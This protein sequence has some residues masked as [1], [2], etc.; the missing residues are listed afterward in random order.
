MKEGGKLIAEQNK[1]M[2]SVLKEVPA[3]TAHVYRGIWARYEAWCVKRG[4]EIQLRFQNVIRFMVEEI[5]GKEDVDTVSEGLK[6]IAR[7]QG[8]DDE[9]RKKMEAYLNEMTKVCKYDGL[10]DRRVLEKISINMWNP[11]KDSL[12]SKHFKTCQ[13][14]LKFLVDFQWKFVTNLSFEERSMVSVRDLRVVDDEKRGVAAIMY[15]AGSE[16]PAFMMQANFESPFV[17]PVFAMAVYYFLRF[18]GVKKLYKG[19]G[20]WLL[21]EQGHVPVIRAKALDQYPRELT[22]GNWYPVCFKYC[23]LPYTKKEWFQVNVDKPRF[24]IP[25][26]GLADDEWFTCGVPNFFIETMNGVKLGGC[27]NMGIDLFPTDLPPEFQPLFHLL[28]KVLVRNLPIL[29]NIF[30]NHDIFIDP[31]LKTPQMI[32]YLTKSIDMDSYYDILQHL[33]D[34][35]SNLH[36]LGIPG[37][38]SLPLANLN[39]NGSDTIDQ[40][41]SELQKLVRMQTSK[42]FSQLIVVLSEIFH[43]LEF[44]RSNKQFVLDLLNSCRKDVDSVI[45]STT[46]TA[47]TIEN[48]ISH[49]EISVKDRDLA[50]SSSLQPLQKKRKYYEEE[51]SSDEESLEELTQLVNQLIT[52]QFNENLQQQTDRIIEAVEPMVKKM[53]HEEISNVL[54]GASSPTINTRD[55]DSNES[56]IFP[57]N[58]SI[59]FQMSAKCNDIESIILEWF[60]PNPDCVH[61]M[62]KR[63]GNKWRKTEPNF[64]LYKLRKP[65]VQYYIHLINEVKMDKFGAFKKLESLLQSQGSIEALSNHLD[66][67]KSTNYI[68]VT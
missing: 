29:Y 3:R 59:G 4:Q 65:I 32:A 18:H 9:E 21:E 50:P 5:V 27:P 10:G 13:D 35:K 15:N 62:N 7:G 20:Y 68:N 2:D 47:T 6:W 57:S 37:S 46:T 39:E 8:V 51:E 52:R 41:K 23:E 60:T 17:C 30:P 38:V 16:G 12:Q 64:S 42:A 56:S 26:E 40:L 1:K 14:K 28:N 54:A 33:V 36:H 11:G 55:S 61:N 45:K 48:E 22:L 34:S 24:L 49:E 63:F 66:I 19:D 44:K 58:N 43:K 25:L 67:Q 31:T 53:V